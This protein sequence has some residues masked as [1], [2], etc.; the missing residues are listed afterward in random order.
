MWSI[1]R[2]KNYAG[3]FRQYF[4]ILDKDCPE[5]DTDFNWKLSETGEVYDTWASNDYTEDPVEVL[6]DAR[7]KTAFV[8]ANLAYQRYTEKSKVEAYLNDLTDVLKKYYPNFKGYSFSEVTEV[9]IQFTEIGVDCKDDPLCD[10]GYCINEDRFMGWLKINRISLEDFITLDKYIV[11]IENKKNGSF[12]K[13]L[14]SG[15]LN[16]K[17]IVNWSELEAET[18]PSKWEDADE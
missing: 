18:I 15:Y 5:R 6:K 9:D 17:H 12:K 16:K 7:D 10:L 3:G 14:K 2:P 4:I 1:H 11:V 13:L 8:I